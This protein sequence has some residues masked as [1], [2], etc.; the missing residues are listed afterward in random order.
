MQSP[1]T[2]LK[3]EGSCEF[4]KHDEQQVVVFLLNVRT[5]RM[6]RI[7]STLQTSSLVFKMHV[8]F[9]LLSTTWKYLKL[10]LSIP[11]LSYLNPR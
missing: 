5:G 3:V 6:V 9:L 8:C 4:P 2:D 10:H 1:V 11:D 7:M